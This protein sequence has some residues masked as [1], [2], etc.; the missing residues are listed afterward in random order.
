MTKLNV[1]NNPQFDL[2]YFTI[3]DKYVLTTFKEGQY[4]AMEEAILVSCSPFCLEFAIINDNGNIIS[5]K[6]VPI[7]AYTNHLVQ[8]KKVVE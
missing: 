8:I 4:H 2:M 3:D 6:D 5:H 1:I 7:S